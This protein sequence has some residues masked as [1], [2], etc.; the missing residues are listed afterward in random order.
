MR[1]ISGRLKG[2]PLVSPKGR[3]LRPT[4][5][6]V[7]ETLFNMLDLRIQDA[8][9]LDLFAGTG[10]VGIEAVSRGAAQAVFVE[11]EKRHVLCLTNNLLRCKIQKQCTVYH[12]DANK[13]LTGIHK[14]QQRIDFAFL[15]P[16]YRQTRMLIDILGRMLKFPIMAESG[17]IVVEHAHTF[18]P[19]TEPGG[20][21]S[22]TKHRRIG[23]TTLSFYQMQQA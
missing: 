18:T 5:D 13:A 22:L 4:S 9:V 20:G 17:L 3:S 16:P 6:M 8:V 15:D 21:F 10:N 14:Q 23:D 2:R 7:K 12:G 1:I 19:P 11:K